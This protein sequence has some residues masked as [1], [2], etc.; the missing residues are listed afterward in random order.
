MNLDTR[1]YLRTN[2]IRALAYFIISH[3]PPHHPTVMLTNTSPL[4][5]DF[6]WHGKVGQKVVLAP[7]PHSTSGQSLAKASEHL[8]AFVYTHLWHKHLCP[9]SHSGYSPS[10]F[11]VLFSLKL[12]F[13]LEPFHFFSHSSSQAPKLH[14]FSPSSLHI[15]TWSA[16]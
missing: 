3:S 9:P 1:L 7:I 11:L 16:S 10:S 12:H 2:R 8:L 5:G 4:K 14:F 13:L 6:C 15:E